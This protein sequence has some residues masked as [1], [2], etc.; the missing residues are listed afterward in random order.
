MATTETTFL[1]SLQDLTETLN[2]GFGQI[3]PPRLYVL[4]QIA[5]EI[6]KLLKEDG[7]AVANFICTHNSRRS[8]LSQTLAHLA[9]AHYGIE[10]LELV[11]SGTEATACNERT[12]AALKRAGFEVSIEEEGSNPKYRLN[13]A[14]QAQPI[15]LWSKVIADASPD[16]LPFVAVMT[17]NHADSN[18][19]VV[20]GSAARISLPFHD[21]KES[22]DTPKEEQT[23]D[24]RLI[25]IGR[26]MFLLIRSVHDRL[27]T[28]DEG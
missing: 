8:Q 17:C 15:R 22:D 20:S 2:R 9:T 14:E 24:Q 3:P 16:G 23:Y 18:C 28:K 25:E 4:N 5:D 11:S 13:F 10:G 12:I 27:K 7:K 19:P 1:P 6:A 21:P 26:E